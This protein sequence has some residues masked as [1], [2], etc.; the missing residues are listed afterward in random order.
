MG[1]IINVLSKKSQNPLII[2][3]FSG[4]FPVIFYCQKN[5]NLTNSFN[6]LLF[7]LTY[8]TL[9][10]IFISVTINLI[11]K[12]K[13]RSDYIKKWNS[14]FGFVFFFGAIN[15]LNFEEPLRSI[16]FFLIILGG[17]VFSLKLQKHFVKFVFFQSLLAVFA[18]INLITKLYENTRISSDWKSL[19][20]DIKLIKLVHRPNIYLIQPD[21]Y[22][23]FSEINKGYYNFDNSD[24]YNYLIKNDF[25][26][27]DNF[28][29]NYSSTLT[30]NSSLFMMKHH[31]YFKTASMNN[32]YRKYVVTENNVLSI[33]KNNNYQT[34][35]IIENPYTIAN[36]PKLGFDSVNI[37]YDNFGPLY[38]WGP[39]IHDV[40]SDFYYFLNKNTSTPQFYFIE[41]YSP[42]HISVYKNSSSGKNKERQAWL[43]RLNETNKSLTNLV[44]AIIDKDPEGLIILL[45]DHGGYVGLDYTNQ[46][47]AKTNDRDLIFSA[48]SSQLSIRWPN[49]ELKNNSPNIKS[50]VNVFRHIFSNLSQKPTYSNNIEANE[51]WKILTKGIDKGVYKYIDEFD[52]IVCD[53]IEF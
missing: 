53:P 22:V 51:S 37:S 47:N 16:I 10:P 40:F 41:F 31:Y 42:G 32:D 14:F 15:F 25:I 27:Y 43:N 24:F 19:P 13:K 39:P 49:K 23:N 20:D 12:I 17:V 4:L 6:H 2:G 52:N 44:G 28:R 3:F 30:S 46:F 26:N 8:F 1:K 33:L 45:G 29:S 35:Y 38:K 9:L 21:G 18:S 50:S 36:Y 7:F 48:F 11:L 34:H 5:F